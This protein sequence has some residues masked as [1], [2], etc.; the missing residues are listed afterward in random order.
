MKSADGTN[1]TV[2]GAATVIL[3]EVV[4]A[5]LNVE[6]YASTPPKGTRTGFPRRYGQS[7]SYWLQQVRCSPLL[8]HRT[9]IDIPSQV[10]TVIVGSGISGTLVAKHHL[11]TWPSKSVVVLE[12]REFCSGATGRNAG[13]CKPDQ[14]RHFAKF[15]KAF[16]QEQ[17]VKIMDNE[18]ATWK[19]LVAY[20]E[21]NKVDCDLWVGDTLDVPVDEE[22]AKAL[23]EMFERYQRAGGKTDHIKVTN[24]P[25]EAA[26]LSK[27]KSAKAC[28][29]WKASTLQPWKLT[30]HIMRDNIEKGTNLQT[31]T[32]VKTVS[33]SETGSRKWTVHTERGDI[34]CDTVVHATNGYSAALEPSLQGIITPK[35]HICDQFVPP[36]SLC[37]SEALQ[38]S[39]GVLLPNGGFFSINSRCTSDGNIMFGGSNPGQKKL[40]E[41]AKQSSER[42][43]DDSLANLESVT[44]EARSFVESELL[45][46]EKAEY[47]PGEGFQY[48]WSGI[49]GLSAD[50]V[51]FVGELPGKPGQWICAGH[52]GHGMARIFTA[53]PGLVKLMHGD[54]WSSTELPDVY[55][56]TPERLAK[57]KSSEENTPQVA[58]I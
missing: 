57:L 31:H 32:M 50:G 56:M 58:V 12:A 14:W 55:Q 17:A 53:A 49:I 43:V 36:R 26:R 29:A 44:K 19:R 21:E 5:T 46:E 6:E 10:D 22:V 18:A 47:G 13:H 25:K 16:G 35:P 30:A 42:C 40:D 23:K 52:H 28:Y 7:L 9:T 2:G 1:S 41:W 45:S 54:P 4:S 3:P 24:D 20:V 39:Y 15:E 27:I 11:A 34:A 33:K 37:G 38:N 51:P 48:S 8:N